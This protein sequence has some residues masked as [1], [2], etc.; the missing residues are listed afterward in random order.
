MQP[1]E[2]HVFTF[3]P[4]VADEM[5][6]RVQAFGSSVTGLGGPDSDVDAMVTLP[7]GREEHEE[8]GNKRG[9]KSTS[10][11]SPVQIPALQQSGQ[12]AAEVAALAKILAEQQHLKL[13]VEHVIAKVPLVR[14]FISQKEYKFDLTFSNPLALKNTI[15]LR[16][17]VRVQQPWFRALALRVKR[18]AKLIGYHGVYVEARSRDGSSGEEDGEG[19]GEDKRSEGSP[20]FGDSISSN[21][22]EGVSGDEPDYL[23]HESP[24]FVSAQHN[25]GSARTLP[26]GAWTWPTS[27]HPPSGRTPAPQEHTGPMRGLSSYAWNLM[28]SYFLFVH[29]H[30]LR[31]PLPVLPKGPTPGWE[32]L[33]TER[34]FSVFLNF[35]AIFRWHHHAVWFP[36]ASV[37]FE[38]A[39]HGGYTITKAEVTSVPVEVLV[40]LWRSNVGENGTNPDHVFIMN[41]FSRERYY[42]KP[43]LL[44]PFVKDRHY[45]QSNLLR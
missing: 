33:E 23:R 41:S 14:L 31:F 43:Y 22:T 35:Y 2:G 38:P 30:S 6:A 18:W 25:S 32:L 26:S 17:Q 20:S 7:G 36:G 34:L 42:P 19:S 28:V 24:E 10:S 21:E 16:Q 11:A 8:E 4:F 40:G 44:D 12:I 45:Q 15:W 27:L 1:D 9:G 5:T 37:E 29:T 13:S 39:A 3:T